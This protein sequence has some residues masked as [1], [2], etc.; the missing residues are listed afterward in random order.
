M[1]AYS[2]SQVKLGDWHRLIYNS[3]RTSLMDAPPKGTKPD[4][5]LDWRSQAEAGDRLLANAKRRAESGVLPA[6]R[7]TLVSRM[8]KWLSPRT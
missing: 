1:N 7:P 4:V 5:L 2:A 8:L 3:H 6:P